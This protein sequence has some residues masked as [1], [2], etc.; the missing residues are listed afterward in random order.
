MFLTQQK[1]LHLDTQSIFSF[2]FI[3]QCSCSYF[4]VISAL[5]FFF[6]FSSLLDFLHQKFESIRWRGS[7]QAHAS[8]HNRNHS[9]Y[10][11]W[12]WYR[13]ID[14]SKKN[15]EKKRINNSNNKPLMEKIIINMLKHG[16]AFF[17]LALNMFLETR[18][19]QFYF[20]GRAFQC[21]TRILF[22]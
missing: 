13:D 15:C 20:D 10:P 14:E 8:Q 6:F 4:L 21:F 22:S 19:P 3:F 7:R 18:S 9:R 1:P 17:A 11:N 2:F 5:F 12:E 16:N